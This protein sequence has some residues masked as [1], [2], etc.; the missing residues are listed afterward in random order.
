VPASRDLPWTALAIRGGSKA[1]TRGGHP[2]RGTMFDPSR[3]LDQMVQSGLGNKG[4]GFGGAALGGVDGLV[5]RA[6]VPGG[7][8]GL[9]AGLAIAAF[10]HLNQQRGAGTADPGHMPPPTATPPPP[11]VPTGR[12]TP[13]PP[14]PAPDMAAAA[15]A[16]GAPGARGSAVST[17]GSQE[18]AGGR[19]MLLIDAMIEAA[20]ADGRVDPEERAKII[21]RLEEQGLES[22]ARTFVEARMALPPAPERVIERLHR[23]H[24]GDRLLAAEVYVASMLA[25]EVDTPAERAYVRDLKE[26]LQL[27]DGLI[28][29]LHDE[30]GVERP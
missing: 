3:L 29:R 19:A 7:G 25:I 9:L 15:G 24:Q 8:M 23:E 16:T 26:R 12:A 13:P 30:L 14:P 4:K 27:D 20:K 22:D 1:R 21:R 11:P 10:E 2:R 17:E 18:H 6:G 28:G 5:R